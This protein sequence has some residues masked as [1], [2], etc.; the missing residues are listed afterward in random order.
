MRRITLGAVVVLVALV[1]T[2]GASA[3]VFDN[4]SFTYDV[5]F[6]AC[7]GELIEGQL[8]QHVLAEQTTDANGNTHYFTTVNEIF[9]G[10]STSGDRYV[11]PSHQTYLSIG[12]PAA[13]TVH[14][15]TFEWNLIQTGENAPADDLQ[16]RAVFEYTF[17]ANGRLTSF[18]FDF[19]DEC[20]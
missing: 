4:E 3:R 11:S 16:M 9:H 8:D 7:N 15:E 6:Q 13:P 12:D 17:D 2:A 1:V 20:Q 10:T 19:T 18:K 14:T 5:L